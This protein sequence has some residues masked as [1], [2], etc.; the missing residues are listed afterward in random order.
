MAE[1]IGA[2]IFSH[3][4][5][6]FLASLL[7]FGMQYY[8]AVGLA[9]FVRHFWALEPIGK[10]GSQ[11][12]QVRFEQR[13]SM[14][15]ILVFSLQAIPIQWAVANDWVRIDYSWS[16]AILP[17]M[18]VLFLWNELHFYTCHRLLHF[19][20]LY[21]K[22][23]RVHHLSIHPTEY[24]TYSFHWIEAFMLGSV[25]YLP[26]LLWDF[27]YQAL[28]FLPLSSITLNMLGHWNHDL[29]PEKRPNHWLRFSF[30]HSLHHQKVKGNY[31]FFLPWLDQVLGTSLTGNKD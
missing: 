3:W 27:H 24:S 28:L 26:L 10:L 20:W 1:Q 21:N 23:H 6:T 5:V 7:F 11:K 4:W 2:L 18:L 14:V 31:G 16:W 9:K 17:E 12:E 8:G 15:S 25:P 19:P 30:R 13:H 22:V 29:A